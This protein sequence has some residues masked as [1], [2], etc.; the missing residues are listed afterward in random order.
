MESSETP[1]EYGEKLKDHFPR[2]QNEICLIVD[3]FN[4]EYYGQ[5]KTG[6]RQ[7]TEIKAAHRS[8]HRIKHWTGRIK[9]WLQL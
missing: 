7:L 3:A 4:R 1:A 8:M 2:L 9:V 6:D 5:M